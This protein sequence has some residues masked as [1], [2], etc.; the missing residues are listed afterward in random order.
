VPRK[1]PLPDDRS[2]LAP[3]A[4]RWVVRVGAGFEAAHSLRDYV[5][6]PEP[7]HGHSW[8]VE[9]ALET[10][11][12]GRYDLSVDFVPTR[13]LVEELA[14]RLDTRCINDIPPFDRLNPTAE[15]VAR[16]FAGEILASGV[17]KRAAGRLAEISIWEGPNNR[18]T[19]EPA[20]RPGGQRSRKG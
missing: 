20:N 12:L 11:R 14:K 6:G 17:T 8:R 13:H 2:R 10:T 15:N 7:L 16:W 5:G 1:S 4:G 18:V 9:V 19:W 3:A